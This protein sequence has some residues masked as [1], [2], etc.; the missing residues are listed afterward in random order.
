MTLTPVKTCPKAITIC[1]DLVDKIKGIVR[2]KG[3]LDREKVK[4]LKMLLDL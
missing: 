4:R 1:N 2:E 3:G